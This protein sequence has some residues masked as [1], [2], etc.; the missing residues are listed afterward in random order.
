MTT[1]VQQEEGRQID[2]GGLGSEH[3]KGVIRNTVYTLKRVGHD[4]KESVSYRH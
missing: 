1:S 4:G 3:Y 2:C